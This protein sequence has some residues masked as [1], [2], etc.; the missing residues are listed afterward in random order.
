MFFRIFLSRQRDFFNK[1]I[2][3][4]VTASQQDF[5]TFIDKFPIDAAVKYSPTTSVSERYCT[6]LSALVAVLA[7]KNCLRNAN[8]TIYGIFPVLLPLST[9]LCLVFTNETTTTSRLFVGLGSADST[10]PATLWSISSRSF[11]I[12][13]ALS[14]AAHTNTHSAELLW[15]IMRE[16][17]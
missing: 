10:P 3:F 2:F 4:R 17:R 5:Q 8:L 16:Y 13:I 9:A 1:K 11:L 15:M 7:S 6:C 14:K 12:A